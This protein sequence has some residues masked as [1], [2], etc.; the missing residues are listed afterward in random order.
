MREASRTQ[1][2]ACE[3]HP[4]GRALPGD[5]LGRW[6]AGRDYC[7]PALWAGAGGVIEIPQSQTADFWLNEPG[8]VWRKSTRDGTPSANVKC[9]NGHIAGLE[10][11]TIAA[12]GT[13]SPSLDCPEKGCDWHV[14]ARLCGWAG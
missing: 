2:V 12:D 7:V 13:V 4:T 14:M 9:G 6:R 10:D 8:P 5:Q 3:P 11:H 1:W